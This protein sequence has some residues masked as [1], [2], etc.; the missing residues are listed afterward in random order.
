MPNDKNCKDCYYF[1]QVY[2]GTVRCCHYIL[3]ED[4]MRPCPPGEG[5]TVKIKGKYYT[6]YKEK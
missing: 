6:K 2:S 1:K 5:C 4:K 3:I